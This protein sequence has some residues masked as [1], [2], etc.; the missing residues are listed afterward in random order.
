MVYTMSHDAPMA[1]SRNLTLMSRV[2]SED[3][4]VG[5]TR[6][7]QGFRALLAADGG[8][9]KTAQMAPATYL[10]APQKTI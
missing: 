8:G 7:W 1:M 3:W 9:I 2:M 6:R 5:D 4:T 10:H